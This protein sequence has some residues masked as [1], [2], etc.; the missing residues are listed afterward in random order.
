VNL[1]KLTLGLIFLSFL[2]LAGCDEI[3]IDQQLISE[4]RKNVAEMTGVDP[5]TSSLQIEFMKRDEY[6]ELQKLH[7]EFLSEESEQN[8]LKKRERVFLKLEKR[9][10][11]PFKE[12]YA[13]HLE[14]E[15][16]LLEDCSQY[17][18]AEKEHCEV[19]QKKLRESNGALGRIFFKDKRIEIYTE[20]IE[21]NFSYYQRF[22][23][24]WFRKEE[25]VYPYGTILHELLHYALWIK[26][27]PV[28]EQHLIMKNKN[29]FERGL[30]SISDQLGS[31]RNG[32]H[33]EMH[34]KSLTIGIE[35]DKLQKRIRARKKEFGDEIM[36]NNEILNCEL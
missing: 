5:E 6:N 21:D 35:D 23:N 13:R 31:P 17:E 11:Q 16:S 12:I 4:I 1:K 3:E 15:W 36:N 26:G 27:V 20:E 32:P 25:K 2:A 22:K 19:D 10:N 9:Y 34:L 28:D 8:C 14:N 24:K 30:D 33:K 18:N 29:Y 7:C